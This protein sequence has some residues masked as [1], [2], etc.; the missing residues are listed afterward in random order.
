MFKIG[1]KVVI[2]PEFRGPH[3]GPS[4]H[5][6]V[7]EENVMGRVQIAPVEWAWKIRPIELVAAHM[8]EKAQ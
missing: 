4:V 5:E 3:E 7:A 8:L 6:V 2:R 1:E